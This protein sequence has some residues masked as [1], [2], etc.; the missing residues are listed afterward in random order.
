MT[1]YNVTVEELRNVVST[2]A[3]TP[4]TIYVKIL[5]GSGG[6]SLLSGSAEP[7]SATGINGN[8]YVQKMSNGHSRFWGPKDSG[9]WPSEYVPLT[10]ATRHV[11][12]QGSAATTWTITHT[13]GGRPAVTV[14][15][16]PALFAG[17]YPELA[18]VPL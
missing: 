14:V 12:A 1:V 17:S 13:L 11:H 5:A 15:D 3:A 2:S 8:W 7:T 16:I 10:E 4:N 6:T 9:S 18:Q